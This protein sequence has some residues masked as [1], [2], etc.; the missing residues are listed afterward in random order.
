MNE[1]NNGVL[2]MLTWLRRVK[3][4]DYRSPN[5]KMRSGVVV[6]C[7][8]SS[9]QFDSRPQ[10]FFFSPTMAVL[11]NKKEESGA[12]QS[13]V[14]VA[15]DQSTGRRF[16]SIDFEK[17]SSL[18]LQKLKEFQKKITNL[19]E[20]VYQ[21]CKKFMNLKKTFEFEKKSRI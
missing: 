21:I 14:P 5:R 6:G 16:M 17:Q 1:Q 2:I 10:Q 13:F 19:K 7:C 11:R 18:C 20:K 3:Y 4:D 12:I 9:P 8:R 15:N